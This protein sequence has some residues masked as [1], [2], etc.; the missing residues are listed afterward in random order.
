VAGVS[1]DAAKLK[2]REAIN[3]AAEIFKLDSTRIALL[4]QFQAAAIQAFVY[5]RHELIREAVLA[6]GPDAWGSVKDPYSKALKV[7]KALTLK[8]A[9][10][11]IAKDQFDRKP[12]KVGGVAITELTA[13]HLPALCKPL[14]GD[15]PISTLIAKAIEADKNTPRR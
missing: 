10:Y 12:V 15:S 3:L 8:G 1:T 2:A 14:P 11:P 5:G 13:E 4:R 6:E 9:R 7:A